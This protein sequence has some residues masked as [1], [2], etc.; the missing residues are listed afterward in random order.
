MP[1]GVLPASSQYAVAPVPA[2]QLK[3]TVLPVKVE[4]GVG[5][6]DHAFR[7]AGDVEGGVGVLIVHPLAADQGPQRDVDGAAIGGQAVDRLRQG[8]RWQAAGLV[9]VV[10]ALRAAYVDPVGLRRGARATR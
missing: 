7:A 9:I 2:V 6:C 3:V 8:G 5:E 4:P 1:P 10:A